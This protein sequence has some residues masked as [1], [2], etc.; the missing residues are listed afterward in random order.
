MQ[1]L[2]QEVV[3]GAE[4]TSQLQDWYSTWNVRTLKQG[5]KLEKLKTEIQKNKV[6]VLGVSE[7]RLTGQGE[8]RSGD[9]TVY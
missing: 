1:A 3:Q 9:F 6:S 2:Q 4:G 8:I 5:G 7:V